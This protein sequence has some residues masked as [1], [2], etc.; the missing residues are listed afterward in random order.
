VRAVAYHGARRQDSAVR[1]ALLSDIHANL[2]ALDAC[3][4]HAR[5]H[6]AERLVFLGDLVG[7]GADAGPV[8]D[9]IAAE[10]DRGALAVK[11]NHDAAMEG[12]GGYFNDAARASLDWARE[13]LSASQ[14]AFLAA[15]PLM[16]RDAPLHF[17]HASAAAPERWDYVDSPGAAL[18]CVQAAG[19][20]YTF[21]GHVHDQALYYAGTTGRMLPFRPVAGTAIPVGAHRRWLAVVG[22][23]GQPRDRNP[24]AAYTLLDT[25]RS[26]VTFFRVPYDHRAAAEKIRRAGLPESLA[27]RVETGI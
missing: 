25:G 9:R 19:T 15:L 6:D 27:Y 7:Y 12:R 17:V 13:A 10:V 14:L 24:A 20:P 11:G 3:L 4:R 26:E 16:V 2:E 5:E 8:V 1:I 23:V 21:V 22:S 18:R